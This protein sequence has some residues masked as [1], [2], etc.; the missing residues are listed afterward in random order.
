[1]TNFNFIS[2]RAIIN[3]DEDLLNRLTFANQLKDSLS[4]WE[5]EESLVI[6][7]KGEWG[8]GKSSIINLIKQQFEQEKDD[9]D[10]TI[11]EFNPWAYANNDSLSFHFFNDIGSELKQ[12]KA[13]KKDNLLA[14][15]LKIYSQLINLEKETKVFKDIVPHVFLLLGILG[16]SANQFFEWIRIDPK[17][18]GNALF[19]LGLFVLVAQLFGGIINKIATF[20]DLRS[21]STEASPQTLKKD[22]VEHLKK[23]NKKLLIIIDDLDRL[24]RKEICEVFKLIRVNADF[25]NT[26]Y[27]LAFDTKIIEANL[28]EENGISGKDYLK[29]I[30]QVDF[31]LPYTKSDRIQQYL[32]SE[33]DKLILVLPNTVNRYFEE[34]EN[35]YWA[36]TYHSGYKNFFKNIRDVKRYINSLLFNINL[37]HKEGIFEVNPIDFFALEVLRVFTPDFYDFIKARKELF[38]DAVE[39]T[40]QRS[41]QKDSRKEEINAA[42]EIIDPRYKINAIKLLNQLFP[43]LD[44]ILKGTGGTYYAKD[45]YSIWRKEL[46]ICSKDH[47]DCYFT[48][49]PNNNESELTQYEIIKLLSSLNDLEL[50]K[51]IL[52]EFIKNNKFRQFLRRI[53]DFTSDFDQISKLSASNLISAL[54]DFSDYIGDEKKGMFDQGITRDLYRVFYQL[55]SREDK[56]QSYQLIKECI[57]N[58]SGISGVLHVIAS[59]TFDYEKNKNEENLLFNLT[60]IEDLQ[61]LIIRKIESTEVNVLL[62]N[63]HF[64]EIINRWKDWGNDKKLI[65]FIESI[66]DNPKSFLTFLQHFTTSSTSISVGSYGARTH[67]QIAFKSLERFI[68]LNE[69]RK[70]IDNTAPNDELMNDFSEIINMFNRDYIKYSNEPVR[71]LNFDNE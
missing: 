1:M 51:K 35:Q 71:Y 46:R 4:T 64:W 18:V 22:I 29:K 41:S 2:D 14:K 8:E 45:Y 31:N 20:M 28:D 57:E 24:S 44:P 3:S 49:N 65:M 25:P 62:E 19:L 68:S 33:L 42:L 6:S 39:S 36:N 60:Q 70:I 40:S 63:K 52:L 17:W 48:L 16:V 55:L 32:F 7:L 11:I 69:A 43:Q 13:V 61:K 34:D 21:L 15:K 67:T 27:L 37:L 30:V 26:I 12:K 66:K 5:N 9:N 56:Q 38:T 59:Q 23:R 53:Q 58:T 10:P 54:N 50:T 47:F